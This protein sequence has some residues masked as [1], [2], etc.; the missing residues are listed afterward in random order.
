MN[1]QP[2]YLE[3]L[4]FSFGFCLMVLWFSI[5]P[6]NHYKFTDEFTLAEWKDKWP[7]DHPK[8]PPVPTDVM[9][10]VEEEDEKPKPV[11]KKKSNL[12]AS[13]K[14]SSKPKPK[15]E[16]VRNHNGYTQL[17]QDCFDVLKSIGIKGVRERKFIVSNTFNKHDPKSVQ[18]FL[19]V[20]LHR[21]A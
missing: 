2:E 9:V 10:D 8:P 12:K 14:P 16:P 13:R 6:R 19:K 18:D 11:A 15:P 4:T 7:I 5:N 17:Q 3:V 1:P 20:S 21:S